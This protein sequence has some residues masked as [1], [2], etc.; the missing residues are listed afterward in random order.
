MR[1]F[2]HAV[3]LSLT[4]LFCLFSTAFA[5]AQIAQT[6]T[7]PAI[8]GTQYALTSL[9][10][11]ATAS[12]G[13]TVAFA[14]VSPTICTVSGTTASLLTPGACVIH[15]TQAG[16]AT[17][18]VAPMVAV[19][20]AVSKATQTITFPTVT[21]TQYALSSLS[22]SAT[23][24]SG[25]AVTLTSAS[26][27]VCT[28][29]GTMATLL[30][31]G[32]CI[33]KANQAGSTLYS[34]APTVQQLIA[35]HLAP[36]TI[37]F[38]VPAGTQYALTSVPLTAT[39]S[40]GL[41]I[42]YTS[43]TPTYCTVTGSTAYPLQQGSCFIHAQQAGNNVYSVSPLVTQ[44]FGIHLA[45][46]TI[47]FPAIAGT[48]YV[49]GT[50]TLS[51]TASSGLTVAF[52]SATPAVCTVSGTTATFKT[53]GDC[54]IHAT[55]AGNKTVYAVAQLVSQ[56]IIVHAIPQTI[57]FPAIT[58]TL[59]AATTLPLSA[60]ASSGLTVAFASATPAVC[61]VSGTT[62]SLLT[63][64]TCTLQATQAGNA[65][66]AAATLVQQNVSVHLASQTI[67]FP[68]IAAQVVGANVTLGATASSGLA[69]TYTSVTTAV[70][71]V[72]GSTATMAGAGACV[73][74]ATQPGNA[75]YG[76][77][78]LVSKSFTVTAN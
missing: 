44:F 76:P 33:V 30:T 9:T 51:A 22:L 66:Y 57:T 28:I 59:T 62:A 24:S 5:T 23:A 41:P 25:L 64:G 52:A 7:F 34:Y 4:A 3:L 37:S 61:T 6:I 47:T 15:A 27:A 39:A 8:T 16:N 55:Q 18:S 58:A 46:Q 31:Q 71:T 40:S 56:S 2:H 53:T 1:K 17:Y 75:T 12:S 77:A 63:S 74:H 45:L 42:T 70:C 11:S 65:N 29:S 72:S 54:V 13:L 73:I 32:T 68:A 49:L 50:T 20:F 35:V 48:Q 21:G 26:T 10:L 43:L 60:T 69:V 78:A 14:S 36:Q 19:A 38:P 67:T